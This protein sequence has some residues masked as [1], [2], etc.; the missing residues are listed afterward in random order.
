MDDDQDVTYS[1]TYTDGKDDGA[2]TTTW[3]RRAGT[4]KVAYTNGDIFEG[5]YS[6]Q[7]LRHGTGIYNWNTAAMDQFAD[8]KPA[9]V[10]QYKGKYQFGKKHGIGKFQYPNGSSY[11]GK[12]MWDKRHGVGTYTYPNGDL[13]S[14]SWK[15]GF[16]HGNGVYV[17]KVSKCQ[18]LGKWVDGQLTEG[19][20]IAD[21][22]T[23]YSGG[24]D[25]KSQPMGPGR[26]TFE[27][28]SSQAGEYK[29][30]P[31]GDDMEDGVK[32]TWAGAG[33]SKA[34]A[35]VFTL[36]QTPLKLEPDVPVLEAIQNFRIVEVSPKGMCVLKNDGEKKGALGGLVLE[37]YTKGDEIPVVYTFKGSLDVATQQ[38]FR[39][40]FGE[41]AEAPPESKYGMMDDDDE[42]FASGPL[43]LVW[44][45]D[46]LIGAEKE[47]TH[48]ELCWRDASGARKWLARK[49][50]DG[51]HEH[52]FLAEPEATKDGESGD[53][54]EDE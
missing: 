14:G 3:I 12:F 39:L 24:F 54:D 50:S 9:P 51:T 1:V 29:A 42:G 23:L 48:V 33:I 32:H 5:Q 11:H 4:A 49:K 7:G 34:A 27:N 38:E 53:E 22:G 16:R 41:Y 13:Y 18:L 30:E 36:T 10:M 45:T 21:D 6:S 31:I 52:A 37:L 2:K 19:K 17:V 44:T 25:E 46:D 40:L 15:A 8:I 43:D 20:W 28:G 35:S 26:F 47:W